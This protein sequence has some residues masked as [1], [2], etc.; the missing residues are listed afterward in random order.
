MTPNCADWQGDVVGA[1]LLHEAE[2]GLEGE[3]E[4]EGMVVLDDE[5][6]LGA[7]LP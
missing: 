4:G 5:H 7:R 6:Q 3:L 1:S 2:D